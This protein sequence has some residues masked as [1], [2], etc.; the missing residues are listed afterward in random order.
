[1]TQDLTRPANGDQPAAPAVA[2]D[3]SQQRQAGLA[4]SCLLGAFCGLALDKAAFH[5]DE[6]TPTAVAIYWLIFVITSG[7]FVEIQAFPSRWD[8]L[9]LVFPALFVIIAFTVPTVIRLV[10]SRR[11]DWNTAQNFGIFYVLILVF[12]PIFILQASLARPTLSHI[13]NQVVSTTPEKYSEIGQR[14]DAAWK[15][16]AVI[17]GMVQGAI[18]FFSK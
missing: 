16:L 10:E 7:L 8:R 9:K 2:P 11:F 1:M 18:L 6:S 15:L 4:F 14:L 12:T 17:L 13:V 5:A 3:I